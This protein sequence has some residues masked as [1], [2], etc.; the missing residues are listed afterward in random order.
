MAGAICNEIGERLRATLTENPDRLPLHILGLKERFNS[1]ERGIAAF[2][3]S[4]EMDKK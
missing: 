3:A 4:I 2:K 1:V